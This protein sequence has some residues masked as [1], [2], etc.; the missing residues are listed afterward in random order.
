MVMCQPCVCKNLTAVFL[1][2]YEKWEE[3]FRFISRFLLFRRSE[4]MC[5]WWLVT[6]SL[7]QICHCGKEA[8]EC[9][10]TVKLNTFETNR[11]SEEAKL[12][13]NQWYRVG[14]PDI[15]PIPGEFDESDEI[16]NQSVRF[17]CFVSKHI[18]KWI[19]WTYMKRFA[20]KN[21]QGV[22]GS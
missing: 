2:I 14:S 18:Y 9:S 21:P 8:S 3:G 1:S 6:C 5:M 15:S 12:L 19:K 7:F 16:R 4:K 10:K 20:K 17:L 22:I 11:V 13:V